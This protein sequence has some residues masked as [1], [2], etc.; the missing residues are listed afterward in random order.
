MLFERP[1]GVSAAM[2]ARRAA[3]ERSTCAK[4]GGGPHDQVG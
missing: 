2:L 1:F 4:H 3:R